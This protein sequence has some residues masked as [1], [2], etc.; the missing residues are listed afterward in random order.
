MRGIPKL[1][2]VS[3][4]A[5]EA[6]WLAGQI[7]TLY[8]PWLVASLLLR[9][10]ATK[11]RWLEPLLL[12]AALVTLLLTY[13]RGGLLIALAAAGITVLV[14]GR[15]NIQR[16]WQW[17]IQPNRQVAKD[18]RGGAQG[19]ERQPVLARQLAWASANFDMI[20]TSSLLLLL[21]PSSSL[22]PS[23][24]LSTSLFAAIKYLANS[25]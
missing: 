20:A 23:L 3:G 25:R 2:R 5:F 11:F 16:S 15:R 24:R 12:L 1:R 6:S 17:L 18:A 7:A 14:A 4:F 10:R 13:S 19:R 22:T 9:F 8:L 21:R